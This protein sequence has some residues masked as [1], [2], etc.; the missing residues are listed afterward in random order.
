MVLFATAPDR[1]KKRF[2][3]LAI[4]WQVNRLNCLILVLLTENFPFAYAY[5]VTNAFL[6]NQADPV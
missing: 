2:T 4:A 6:Y 5:T 3:C 1:I